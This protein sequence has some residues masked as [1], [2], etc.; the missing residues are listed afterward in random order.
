MGHHAQSVLIHQLD[1]AANWAR[2]R[3]ACLAAH[4]DTIMAIEVI[5]WLRR[6]FVPLR[7]G[8]SIVHT[9]LRSNYDKGG[10]KLRL[11]L[12]NTTLDT[13]SCAWYWLAA[14]PSHQII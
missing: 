9:Y 4:P 2:I 14:T 13:P 3:L 10:P 8:L 12:P 1:S 11:Q 6:R 5:Q 7:D